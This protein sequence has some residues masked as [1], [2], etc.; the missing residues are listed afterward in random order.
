MSDPVKMFAM[1][2]SIK[3]T[4]KVVDA[5]IGLSKPQ[6]IVNMGM[7]V[8]TDGCFS[9]QFTFGVVPDLARSPSNSRRRLSCSIWGRAAAD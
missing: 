2:T 8:L 1:Q 3:S 9:L 6:I 5:G 4:D 7:R